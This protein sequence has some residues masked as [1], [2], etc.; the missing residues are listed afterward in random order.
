MISTIDQFRQKKIYPKKTR[1]SE[2]NE[3]ESKEKMG[4][5][6]TLVYGIGG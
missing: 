4:T 3:H 2:G 5:D 6:S 1:E